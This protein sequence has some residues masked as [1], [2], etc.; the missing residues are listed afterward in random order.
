MPCRHHDVQVFDGLRCCLACGETV[1]DIKPDPEQELPRLQNEPYRYDS[2]DY[3]LG[4]EIRLC[5]LFAG[6]TQDD[7][8]VDLVHVDIRDQPPYEAISYAWATETG[9]DRLS[10]KV[11]CRGGTI[12]VTQT[13]EAALRRLRFSGRNRYLWVDAVCID[14]SNVEERN[15]QVGF[16]GTIYAKASQVL[17]YLGPGN[18]ST[19]RVIDL[20]KDET[21]AFPGA[22]QGF[23]SS[24][25]DFL[26]HRWFD[27][28]WILQEIALAR[29]ATMVAGERTVHWTF[30]T[31]NRLLGLCA[32]LSIE[33]P[34]ALRWLPASQPEQDVLSVLHR[35]RNCSSTDPRDKVFAVLGLVQADFQN[36]F[37]IDYS[38]TAEE[39]YTQLLLQDF[40]NDLPKDQEPLSSSAWLQSFDRWLDYTGKTFRARE[41]RRSN[42]GKTHIESIALS[43]T[44]IKSP[45]FHSAI[46]QSGTR[47][48]IWDE[49][50][51]GTI[52]SPRIPC[53]RVRAHLLDIISKIIGVRSYHHIHHFDKNLPHILNRRRLCASC[54]E[55]F[56]ATPICQHTPTISQT[57]SEEFDRDMKRVLGD[58]KTMF[59]TERSVGVA[60]A[61]VQM[62]DEIFALDGADV[63]FILR[64]VWQ[65]YVLVGECFLYRAL[66][67]TLCTCCG[68]KTE[69]WPIVTQVIDIM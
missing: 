47:L 36:S 66:R 62:H 19:N 38:L 18:A 34:S 49:H 60:R 48:H 24:I 33:P 2:L 40:L 63:P 13:C 5:V 67:Q 16:M 27:R 43:L 31:I 32:S 29:L 64:R 26:G 37:P 61:D 28:V 20:L 9:D 58:G 15:H 54:S 11:Y 53:L 52:P 4:Q 69:E 56:V 68:Y 21:Y 41:R 22:R 45:G 23:R 6:R 3:S 8:V 42:V 65:H 57:M 12:S 35:C 25:E 50:L 51:F 1:F 30:H 7:V 14:Q 59:E 39:V 17:I 55:H 10:Q 44:Q 46:I